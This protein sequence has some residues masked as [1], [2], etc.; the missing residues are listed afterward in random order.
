[1]TR[2]EIGD[3]LRVVA[4]WEHQRVA[5]KTLRPGAM[6]AAAFLDEAKMMNR[7]RHPHLVQL[8]GVCTVDEPVYIITELMAHG[9][10]RDYLRNDQGRTITTTV[11]INMA[12][13]VG[14]YAPISCSLYFSLR[15]CV[16]PIP[17]LSIHVAGAEY[18][19][20]GF[21]C[22]TENTFQSMYCKQD[23]SELPR[24][25]SNHAGQRNSRSPTGTV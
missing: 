6:S 21:P 12:A 17:L 13:Q 14:L 15:V 16:M 5:V 25:A 3:L 1:M 9:S 10:L 18:G 11:S 8:L 2:S 24:L 19:V 20:A 23:L 7:L 22:A 4:C